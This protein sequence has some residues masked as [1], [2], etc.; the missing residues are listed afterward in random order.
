MNFGGYSNECMN[1]RVRD[2][3]MSG[4]YVKRVLERCKRV[5]L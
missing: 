5:Y 2:E 4:I 1:G 3:D